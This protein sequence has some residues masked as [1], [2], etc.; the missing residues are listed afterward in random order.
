MPKI[1][2]ATTFSADLWEC[3][4]KG[5][6]D[7]F[8]AT[9]TTGQLVA[10]VEGMDVPEAP[11]VVSRRIDDAPI[12][13]AVRDANK[14]V[15]PV[16]LGGTLESPECGCKGGPFLVH[17]KRHKLPCPGYWFCKNAIRWFR[18]PLAAHLACIE[19]AADYDYL[20]WVDADASFRRRV[21]DRAVE[22]WFKGPS[23]KIACIYLKSRRTAIET[24]V[25]GYNLKHGGPKAAAAVLAR[26]TSGR[27]RRDHRWDDCVQLEKGLKDARVTSR[28]LA[29]A[30]GPRNTVIQ[31]SP[32]GSYLGHDKGRHNRAKKLV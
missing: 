21:P 25:F 10:Y 14:A 31:F 1:L 12:L 13:K 15:I 5:L 19:F 4:G 28:D 32:L 9:K 11:H 30:V 2:W 18:K 6:V 8:V 27:Y 7:S 22:G 20:M 26:Y 3:S 16:A 23:A 29:T 17:D 24:G